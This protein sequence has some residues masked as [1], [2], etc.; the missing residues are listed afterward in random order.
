MKRFAL[1]LVV[2]SSTLVMAGTPR[3]HV[4][5]KAHSQ[6]NFV[7]EARFISAHGFFEKWDAEVN[8]DPAQID[9]ASLKITIDAASINTRIQ[10]RDNHLRSKDF[11]DVAQYPTITFV[12][13]KV[14]KTGEQ[15][16]DVVGNLTLRGVTKELTVPLMMVFYENNR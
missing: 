13:K 2:L 8:L 10:Q 1:L 9:S 16:Y 3:P 12:S 7:G 15:K 5:D 14:N 4:I 11:F 6:I